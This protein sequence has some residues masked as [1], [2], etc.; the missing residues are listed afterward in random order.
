VIAECGGYPPGRSGPD[1]CSRSAALRA[2]QFSSNAP[3]S[4][5]NL[6]YYPKHNAKAGGPMIYKLGKV[7]SI[8]KFLPEFVN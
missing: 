5:P 2:S 1:Q 4:V 3:N 8:K 7:G 6:P